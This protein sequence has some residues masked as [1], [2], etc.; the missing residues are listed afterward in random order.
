MHI[1]FILISLLP[2]IAGLLIFITEIVLLPIFITYKL[3]KTPEINNKE[4]AKSLLLAFIISFTIFIGCMLSTAHNFSGLSLLFTLC[5]FCL[6][7]IVLPIWFLTTLYP[8]S[9]DKQ[10]QEYKMLTVIATGFIGWCLL[11][12]FNSFYGKFHHS[13]IQS[14]LKSKEPIIIELNKYKKEHGTYPAK[15]KSYSS[16]MYKTYN[17]GMDFKLQFGE[18]PTYYNYCTNINIEGC[19][20]KVKRSAYSYKRIGKWVEEFYRGSL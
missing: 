1:I 19:N 13:K 20:E 12:S 8:K 5:Y 6:F 16:D 14:M 4:I 17:H 2:M 15:F 10:Q 18:Y 9:Q 7:F 11:F 3:I